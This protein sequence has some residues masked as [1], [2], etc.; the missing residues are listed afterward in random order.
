M[1]LLLP[2][3]SNLYRLRRR[4]AFVVLMNRHHQTVGIAYER[5]R[6][7]Y[8]DP[9]SLTEPLIN[10]PAGSWTENLSGKD[11]YALLK[12]R[13]TRNTLSAADRDILFRGCRALN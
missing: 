10:A 5:S 1:K 9:D 2:H 11:R 7:L 13:A 4:V 3:D 12:R 6:R 8:A